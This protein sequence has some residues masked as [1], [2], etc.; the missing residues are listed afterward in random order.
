MPQTKK[1]LGIELAS[2][3]YWVIK[4]ENG[5]MVLRNRRD[6]SKIISPEIYQKYKSKF[7]ERRIRI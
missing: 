7:I 5:R 1:V 4:E 6:Q 2:G 3:F